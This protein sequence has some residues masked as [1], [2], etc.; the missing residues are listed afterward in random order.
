MKVKELV[1]TALL[2]AVGL[3][4]HTITPPLVMGIKP[5]FLLACMFLCILIQPDF[6]TTL[7][8]GV[9]AGIMAAL[10]TQMP[11]GQIPSLFDKLLS[12]L[13]LYFV[14]HIIFRNH[15]NTITLATSGFFGTIASGIVFLI[16]VRIIAGLPD[17]FW[18]LFVA[19]VLPTALANAVLTV[20]VYQAITLARKAAGK[21]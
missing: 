12:A 16:G 6:Q 1:Q 21:A 7:V 19:I 14:F 15:A 4:L 18:S 17:S 11:G 3:V 10:T 13:M 20:I 9:G 2:L 5:D 8:A